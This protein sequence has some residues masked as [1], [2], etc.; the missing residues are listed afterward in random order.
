MSLKRPSWALVILVILVAA[1]SEESQAGRLFPG[2]RAARPAPAPQSRYPGA[3][4]ESHDYITGREVSQERECDDQGCLITERDAGYYEKIDKYY[5][6]HT[7]GSSNGYSS[8]QFHSNSGES[9][10]P[11]GRYYLGTDRRGTRHYE[12]YL[13][14]YDG[15]VITYEEYRRQMAAAHR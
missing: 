3:T 9:L 6:P 11:G 5:V 8:P 2:R 7:N 12:R 10:P 13:D 4:W 15:H 1:L 14:A